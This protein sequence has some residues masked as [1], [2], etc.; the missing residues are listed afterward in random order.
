YGSNND[1][2]KM[3]IGYQVLSLKYQLLKALQFQVTI[4]NKLSLRQKEHEIHR[5]VRNLQRSL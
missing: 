4:A 2:L 5:L 3:D 1:S